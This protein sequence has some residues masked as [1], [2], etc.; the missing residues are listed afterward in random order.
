ML[1][2]Q[3][4]QLQLLVGIGAQWLNSILLD[5]HWQTQ[6]PRQYI[7][8]QSL[9]TLWCVWVFITTCT[10][11]VTRYR[12]RGYALATL[13]LMS[14][15][16]S[17]T[18]YCCLE[19]EKPECPG[20][21]RR[22]RNTKYKYKTRLRLKTSYN[23]LYFYCLWFLFCSADGTCKRPS[24]PQIRLDGLKELQVPPPGEITAGFICRC[25]TNSA[26][27]RARNRFAMIERADMYLKG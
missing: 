23:L 12:P 3:C 18:G 27:S 24:G 9:A 1:K 22:I 15:K 14:S 2:D 7:N 19:G 4:P 8:S 21:E 16:F 6:R 13:R 10:E 11:V 17:S 5:T 20:G 25:I 26:F